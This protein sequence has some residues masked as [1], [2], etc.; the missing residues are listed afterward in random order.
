MQLGIKKMV[1]SFLI[2]TILFEIFLQKTHQKSY[3]HEN[4]E[5]SRQK[6]ENKKSI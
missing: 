2:L 6:G 1:C 4:F 5:A 3:A